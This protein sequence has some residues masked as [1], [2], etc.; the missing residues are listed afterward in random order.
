M[1]H[2][3]N[4]LFYGISFPQSDEE[5]SSIQRRKLIIKF[6]NATFDLFFPSSS[7]YWGQDITQDIFHPSQISVYIPADNLY[8]TDGKKAEIW[9]SMDMGNNYEYLELYPQD[10]SGKE[11]RGYSIPYQTSTS[12]GCDG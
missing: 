4:E 1:K 5:K 11:Y 8:Y 3:D 6:D 10:L 9:S 7:I 2:N 12:S